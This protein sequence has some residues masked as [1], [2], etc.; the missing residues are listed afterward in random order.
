MWP[1]SSLTVLIC[2]M[3]LC[4]CVP[5]MCGLN[6]LQAKH[7]D[8]L[9]PECGQ[10]V[11][12][13]QLEADDD[14]RLNIPLFQKCLA[15]KKQFCPD[16]QPGHAAV[17]DCLVEHRQEPGFSQPCRCVC[18]GGGMFRGRRGTCVGGVGWGDVLGGGGGA[19]GGVM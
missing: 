9:N 17:R 16:V 2:V 7:K 12:R 5:F 10:E 6:R 18:F 19:G 8:K 1:G 15:D 3:T 11:F 14:I 13:Q 4:T